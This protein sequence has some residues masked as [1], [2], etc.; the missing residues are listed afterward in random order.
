MSASARQLLR[1]TL[2]TV[3]YRGSKAIQNAPDSFAQYGAPENPQTPAKIL[4]HICDLYDWAL[5]MAKGTPAWNDSKP[6]AWSEEIARFHRTLK[7]F[8]DYLAS[9]QPLQ[10]PLEKLFQGPIAD[11]LTHIGQL[12]ML[13][14]LA[15]CKISGENYFAADINAGVVGPD[16]PKPRKEF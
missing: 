10:S 11:S 3:A 15:G 7:A 12:A 14:R 6:L 4:A 13:R 1:H 8:D 2:A 16:Q 9:D 5:N